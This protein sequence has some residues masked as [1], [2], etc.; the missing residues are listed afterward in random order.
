MAGCPA[1]QA[2]SVLEKT[3]ALGFFA[4]E[5]A[6][7]ADGLGLLACALLGGLLEMLPKLHLA[8]DALTLQLLFQSPK[9]LI[10]IVVANADLHVVVTTFRFELQELQ[11]V[12]L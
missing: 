12:A 6:G 2:L 9:G 3:F 4:C 5:F 7:A 11:E 10:D 8:E 1:S